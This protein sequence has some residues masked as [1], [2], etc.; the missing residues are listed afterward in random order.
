[1]CI[2]G[3]FHPFHNRGAMY[4]IPTIQSL[5]SLGGGGWGLHRLVSF[6]NRLSVSS[7]LHVCCG[8]Q[9]HGGSGAG[10]GPV[11]A[12]HTGGQWR[13]SRSQRSLEQ[14]YGPAR[15]IRAGCT[16]PLDPSVPAVRSRWTHPCR[17]PALPEL[18]A[19]Y[20]GSHSR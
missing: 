4:G 20:R 18:P 11:R 16:V 13:V 7:N 15:P 8:G 17:L 9:R 3:T 14:L 19:K 10:Q 12:S 1:M 2:S 6:A 5:S